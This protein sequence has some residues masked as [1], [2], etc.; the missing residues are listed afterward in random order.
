MTNMMGQGGVSAIPTF[1]TDHVSA[2]AGMWW[3]ACG[4]KQDFSAPTEN[5]VRDALAREGADGTDDEVEAV[6]NLLASFELARQRQ[7]RL[8]G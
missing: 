6:Q 5:L 8:S 1:N 4:L 2:V 3:M 7:I